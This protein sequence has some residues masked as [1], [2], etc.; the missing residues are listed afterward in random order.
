MP[1]TSETI[2][3]WDTKGWRLDGDFMGYQKNAPEKKM[4]Q[5][6]FDWKMK[7]SHSEVLKKNNCSWQFC[8]WPYFGW[9]IRD[10]FI[11]CWWPPRIGGIK[12]SRL[13]ALEQGL[14]KVPFL[15]MFEVHHFEEKNDVFVMFKA[16]KGIIQQTK[17]PIWYPMF[18]PKMSKNGILYRISKVSWHIIDIPKS[19][20]LCHVGSCQLSF[21]HLVS[22]INPSKTL[23]D[24][25]NP[26]NSALAAW[27]ISET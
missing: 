25:T 18:F 21:F 15:G 3:R 19:Y 4:F 6:F 27:I 16:Y 11:G 14:P 20:H 13:E 7:I 22:S 9:V 17:H 5:V 23:E 8:W 26:L 2:K 12:R 10:P 1:T 24:P